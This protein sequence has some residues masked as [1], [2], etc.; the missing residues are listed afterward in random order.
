[1]G[2]SSRWCAVMVKSA[3]CR[4]GQVGCVPSVGESY[5]VGRREP[6]FQ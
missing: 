3:V 2:G 5:E 1:M 6:R 4:H